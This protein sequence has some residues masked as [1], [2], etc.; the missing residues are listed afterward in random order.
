MNIREFDDPY[1]VESND[2]DDTIINDDPFADAFGTPDMYR[3][4][5]TR[6][7]SDEELDKMSVRE[8]YDE[9]LKC[10]KEKNELGQRDIFTFNFKKFG[11]A[12][13]PISLFAISYLY[14]KTGAEDEFMALLR[15]NSHLLFDVD[16]DARELSQFFLLIGMKFPDLDNAELKRLEELYN[17]TR[18]CGLV[19]EL[20]FDKE[21]LPRRITG[22]T[23]D[24]LERRND[25]FPDRLL[26]DVFRAFVRNSN[27]YDDNEDTVW[28]IYDRRNN[29][30]ISKPYK[31][32][33]SGEIIADGTI[34]SFI[35]YNLIEEKYGKDYLDF[36]VQKIK[37]LRYKSYDIEL[38][39]F[40]GL[41]DMWIDFGHLMDFAKMKSNDENRLLEIKRLIALA[42]LLKCNSKTK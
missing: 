32:L 18:Y 8:R 39:K 16:E 31:E 27:Q 9:R 24:D 30:I 26:D 3:P 14:G 2:Y 12:A 40:R 35:F 38:S 13:S 29:C 37:D 19:D 1:Y 36:F 42:F 25:S 7:Y 15:M 28:Q 22:I 6:R 5:P 33:G 41:K 11:I 17:D 4:D 21:L 10:S 23:R 20:L 34:D